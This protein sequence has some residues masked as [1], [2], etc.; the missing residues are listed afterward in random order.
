MWAKCSD[1][2]GQALWV[3]LDNAVTVIGRE[4][5]EPGTEIVFIGGG[6]VI[7]REKPETLLGRQ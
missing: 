7:V 2:N 1:M 5:P 3:N 6:Q 4:V